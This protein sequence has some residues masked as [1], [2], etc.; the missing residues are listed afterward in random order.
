[1]SVPV[2]PTLGK[3]K[4]EGQ[5]FKAR[6]SCMRFCL[7]KTK[8]KKLDQSRK[9][10]LSVRACG[11]CFPVTEDLGP[12]MARPLRLVLLMWVLFRG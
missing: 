3:L 12:D 5:V 9:E 7:K 11:P 6:F 10:V 1:M 4:Q 8:T 2:L